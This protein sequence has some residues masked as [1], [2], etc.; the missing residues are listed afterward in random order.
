MIFYLDIF[1]RKKS[2]LLELLNLTNG[3]VHYIWLHEDLLIFIILINK[4]FQ[5]ISL[6]LLRIQ[7]HLHRLEV[8]GR[9]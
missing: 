3:D 1:W 7:Q 8:D 4:D 2:H 9:M 6:A 5:Y